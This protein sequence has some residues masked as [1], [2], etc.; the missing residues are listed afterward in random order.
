[1]E[2][3]RTPAHR[4]LN[5]PDYP[6]APHHVQVGSPPLRMHYVDEGPRNG[7]VVLMLHGEPSW[8]YLYRHMIP[9]C[10]K[11]GQRVIAPDLI[12]FG[13]SDKPTRI[14]DYTYARHVAW[15]R[16]LIVKLDLRDITLVCQDWGSL[17]GLRLAAENEERFGRIAL[18]NGMLPTGEQHFPAAFKIWRTF[19]QVS[20]WFPISGILGVGT[21][22]TLSA[23]ERAAYDAPFPNAKHQAGAR[24]FPALVPASLADPAS[25]ANIAAWEVLKRWEK[26]FLLAFS[27]GDPIT[28]GGDRY[29]SERVPGSKGQPHVTLRGG[30]FVQEDS[31]LEFATAINE[32]IARSVR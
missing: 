1:M 3:L 15:V 2:F 30:H 26:P 28:K 32:L 14:T 25:A 19:A 23:R 20:P 27:N 18:S 29:V 21:R 22:R 4:F 10:V 8:S 6:F 7:P 11:A 12:G 5:L 13:K 9:V 24:A 17:I 31:P 16:D